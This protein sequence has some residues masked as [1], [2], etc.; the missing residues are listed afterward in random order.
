MVREPLLK[1]Q[2]LIS[3]SKRTEAKDEDGC[4]HDDCVVVEK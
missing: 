3:T 1:W 2:N 4:Q